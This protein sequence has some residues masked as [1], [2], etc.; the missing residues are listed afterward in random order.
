[1]GKTNGFVTSD[2]EFSSLFFLKVV[3]NSSVEVS[4]SVNAFTSASLTDLLDEFSELSIVRVAMG[5][6]LMVRIY[7]TRFEMFLFLFY[8]DWHPEQRYLQNRETANIGLD[9]TVGRAPANFDGCWFKSSLFFLHGRKI[10]IKN[11]QGRW[12]QTPL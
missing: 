4:Q 5:Y 8:I 11:F 7:R 3:R 6:V 1:M 2:F 12:H 9:S 10:S